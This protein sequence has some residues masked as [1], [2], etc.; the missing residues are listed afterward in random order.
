MNLNEYQQQREI[1]GRF[2]ET[3][4][5]ILL[6][7]IDDAS[8]SGSYKYHLQ[9]IQCRAKTYESLEKRLAELGKKEASD[10]EEIRNDLAGCRVIF[11][12]ND[13]LSAFLSSGLVRNNFNVHST[14]VHGPKDEITSANDFYTANHYIIELDENRASL[15]EYAPFK[16]LKCEIQI[17]TVLNHAWAETVHDMTYKKPEASGFGSRV[18]DGIDTRLQ[19]IMK[20]Y[21]RPAGYE[22]QKVQHDYRRF[23]EGKV[24]FDRNVKQEIIDSQ[25]NNE[26]H[27]ILQRFR[28]STLPLYDAE[29]FTKELSSII[30]IVRS[31]TSTARNVK[32]VEISTPIGS[33]EGKT[34]KDILDVALSVLNF[35]QYADVE[36]VFS[37]LV[38]FYLAAPDTEEKEA[39]HKAAVTLVKYEID[40]LQKAGFFVQDIVLTHLE[41][42]D[43]ATLIQVRGL[44]AEVGNTILDPS[45]ESTSYKSITIKQ[46]S[47]PGNDVMAS[48]RQRAL[49]LLKRIYN[50]EDP[51]G[52]KRPII[53]AFN[54]ATRTPHMG[55]YSDKLLALVLQ[56]SREIIDFYI[57]IIPSDSYEILESIEEDVSFLYRRAKDIVEGK[58]VGDELCQ[59]HSVALMESAM[60]FRK[61]LNS[62]PEFVIYKTL[63][64]YESVFDES[65]ENTEWKI[66]DEREFREA[67]ADEY[68][69]GITDEN[70]D[71]WE[72]I[73]IRCTWTKSDDMATFLYFGRFL[74]TLATKNPDF[75]FY[76]LS[77]HEDGLANFLGSI[78]D[79]LLRGSGHDK[80]LN[81]MNKWVDEGK[82]LFFCARVF[83]Y[84]QPLN[85]PLVKKVLNKARMTSE[86]G[87]LI[88]VMAAA[89]K[90]YD[91]SNPH[92][93]TEL[94]LPAVQELTK[95]GN[96]RWAF[97]F[98]YRAER[99]SVIAALDEQGIDIV[100]EN[101]LLLEKIDFNAEE[102]LV[103]IAKQYPAKIL[104]FFKTRLSAEKDDGKLVSAFD[105][106][107]FSFHHL[108]EPLSAFP[109]LVVD[110]VSGWY[111]GDYG[112]FIY[113]GARLIHNIFPMLTDELK[114]KLVELVHTE[115]QSNLLIVMGVL[116]NYNGNVAIKAICKEMVKVLPED[117]KLLSEITIILESTDGVVGEFG[118]VEAYKRKKDEIADWLIDADNKVKNFAKNYVAMLD[119]QITSEKRRA[120]ESI[121][122]HKHQFGEE[123]S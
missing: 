55:K 71:F 92:L 82:H 23:L 19:K 53:G 16:G 7:A 40:V 94:F 42:L 39:I 69:N 13:D 30:E 58:K 49:A 98:W 45:T 5:K 74:N 85:E 56:N 96:A 21:L 79:G 116:R 122:L 90:N 72:K 66:R 65:W 1:Y 112:F 83:E 76:L 20:D 108:N 41:K 113:R 8:A 105:A 54:T 52:E 100:L 78:L 48:I 3:V 77:K 106:I 15:P 107:P 75:A 64:G 46:G 93:I 104:D 121:E 109:E 117:S 59:E 119:K 35:I 27:E 31:A 61:E 87:A 29:Y 6:A 11:Y 12:Y 44:V 10:I 111:D 4:R 22:F 115:Q 24:L 2:A 95:L 51:D 110:T 101:L 43:D 67:K 47:V 118:Y 60:K 38:E 32:P 73:T 25:N 62:N 91:S 103:P 17:H 68:A 36:S 63:V 34:F 18:L 123:V 89:A 14:K 50:P 28:E 80:A 37:C 114:K 99:S 84:Y 81:L 57:G 102:I 120:E 97:D 86:V 33:M 9:Q 26:R 70:K 88:K